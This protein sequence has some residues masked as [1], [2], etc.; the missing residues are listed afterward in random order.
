MDR[1]PLE[2][3]IALLAAVGVVGVM[4]GAV[5][6]V[7]GGDERHAARYAAPPATAEHPPPDPEP[8]RESAPEPALFPPALVTKIDAGGSQVRHVGLGSSDAIYVQ[9]VEGGLT[10]LLSVHWGERPDVLGPVRS[11]RETDIELLGQFTDAVYAYSGSA[12]QLAGPLAD[13]GLTTVAPHHS[14]AFYRD[15]SRPSP[16]NLYV[17]PGRLP[18]TPAAAEPFPTG[19]PPSGGEP[20]DSYRVAY[21]SA[22]YDFAWS[23]DR[24]GWLVSMNGSP[25]T[26]A[27]YG[28]LD[29]GTVVV[30]RVPIEAG[31]GITD[32]T[33]SLS[34][35]ARTVGQGAAAVLRDGR[36][37]QGSWAR[38]GA[39]EPLRL[40]TGGGD[41][42]PLGEGRLW[43]LLVPA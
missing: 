36:A 22:S 28:R 29:A 33:G 40:V 8:E 32:S 6:L 7:G 19:A 1:K 30:L 9:P 20:V 42:I 16:H 35:V 41:P 39:N 18:G 21:Q 17:R 26:S 3:L 43:V 24:D 14:N 2:T 31:L 34:P 10:R 13:S 15:G 27:E 25:F 5:L 11:A 4:V 38:D 37:Y 23:G 12:S